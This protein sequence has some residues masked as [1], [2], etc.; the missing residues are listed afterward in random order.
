MHPQGASALSTDLFLPRYR[1]MVSGE[2]ELRL[3][4]FNL[5]PGYWSPPVMIAGMAALLRRGHTWMSLPAQGFTS[6]AQIADVVALQEKQRDGM[7][8]HGEPVNFFAGIDDLPGV[9]PQRAKRSDRGA[10]M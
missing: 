3:V 5:A 8:G 10:R 6:T 9:V 4:G 7:T 1:P 2:W